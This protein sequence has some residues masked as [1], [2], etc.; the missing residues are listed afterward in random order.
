VKIQKAVA[1]S[2]RFHG[3]PQPRKWVGVGIS[4]ALVAL[5]NLVG[6]DEAPRS[7][8]EGVGA[9]TILQPTDVHVIGTSESLAVVEDLEVL[10]NG[11]VWVLNSVEPLFVG[12]DPDGEVVHEYGS[13]GGGPEEFGRPSAFVSRGIDGEAWV[14]DPQRH[15]LIE[16][17]QSENARSRIPLPRD[18]L[19]QGSLITGLSLLS[20]Q[21]R[22]AR[23][24]EEIILPR[25][26][27]SL[28]SGMFSFSRSIWGADLLALNRENAAVRR[29]V[30]LGEILGDPTVAFESFSQLPPALLWFRL[31]AVCSG[32][33]IRVYDRLRN[34]VRGFTGDGT[35]LVPTPLPPVGLHEA[36]REQFARAI[37]EFREA[38]VTGQV[39]GALS[40]ADSTRLINQIAQEADLDPAQLAAILPRYV[41]L[42]CTEEG[43]LW[44]QLF[45]AEVGGLRG[46]P[47][48]LRIT[49]DGV[50]QEIHFP[51]R[52]DPYR[53]T[54]ER[55]WGV[56]RD[57]FDVASVGW[58]G[59]PS[60]R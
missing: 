47:A 51:D 55:I 19:P 48:W 4:M 40:A 56:Q 11:M 13:L 28:A 32:S 18:S 36:T 1:K 42:R 38:E 59:V 25:S 41:D 29:V 15:A 2:E 7:V 31:W 39:G 3:N 9:P 17:S 24:G 46:G 21:V 50:T 22:T 6:C 14:F 44:M 35:E 5:T 10:S 43:A 57:E 37:F 16:I 58:I 49:P 53:F 34:E 30:S 20:T 52:F 23:L 60:L 45:D 8:A 33:E 26:I 12:F 54:S 27:G